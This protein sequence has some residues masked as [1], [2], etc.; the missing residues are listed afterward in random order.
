MFIQLV[1]AP[2]LLSQEIEFFKENISFRLTSEFFYV[3]GYYWFSNISDKNVEKLIFYPFGSTTSTEVIDSVE[4]FNMT[5]GFAQQVSKRSEGGIYFIA[6][7]AA[8]DT[9]VYRIMYRQK[10]IYDGVGYILRST[11]QWGKPLESAEYTLRVRSPIDMLSCTYRPDTLY[12]IQGEKIYYWKKK[13][14]LP[15]HDLVFHYSLHGNGE[16]SR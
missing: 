13:N 11:R 9:V 10:L 6:T 5:K 8:R 12:S 1:L 7:L 16:V 14:F 15:D 3:D 4:V 2:Y